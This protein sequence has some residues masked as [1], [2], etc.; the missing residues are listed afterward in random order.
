MIIEEYNADI[1]FKQ[2]KH[3]LDIAENAFVIFTSNELLYTN[4]ALLSLIQTHGITINNLVHNVSSS[5][6]L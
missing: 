3:V 2:W 1:M 4:K 5:T 6:H